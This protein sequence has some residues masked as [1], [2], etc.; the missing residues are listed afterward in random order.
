VS[1]WQAERKEQERKDERKK[2]REKKK[3]KKEKKKKGNEASLIHCD[4]KRHGW[5]QV[6]NGVIQTGRAKIG[7]NHTTEKGTK[8][9]EKR[10]LRQIYHLSL[11]TRLFSFCKESVTNVHAGK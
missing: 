3:E 4:G 11:Y 5:T 9:N 6:N 8:K 7:I 10:K 1:S 2:K